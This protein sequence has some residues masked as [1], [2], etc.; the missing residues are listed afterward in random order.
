MI[1]EEIRDYAEKFT[2]DESEILRELREKTDG[3]FEKS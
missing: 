3:R 2:F 1:A